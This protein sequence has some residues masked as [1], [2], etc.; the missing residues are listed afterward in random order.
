[1]SFH[2]PILP[3]LIP[4]IGGLLMLLPP[5]IGVERYRHRRVA[6]LLLTLLQVACGIWLMVTVSQHGAL[7]YA[8][9][10]WQP[11]FGIILYADLLSSMLIALTSFLGLGIT[12]YSF[13]GTDREGKYYHPLIQF[14]LLGISG[15]F[16]TNDLFNLF[17]FF[18]VL[19]IASYALMVHGGGKQKTLANVHYVIL[20]LIGSSLF[21]IAL[22]T[23]YAA[24]GT[25][26]IAD[27]SQRMAELGPSQKVIAQVGGS[28]LLVVFGLKAAMLPLHFWLPQTYEA[29]SAPVAA[30]FA[31]MT[32]V[33]VY[34]IFR[35][36]T[37]IFGDTAGDLA[38]MAEPWIWVLAILT[39]TAG[40][41]G[42]LASPNLR[43]LNSN[44]IIVSV[45][46][47]LI[48]FALRTP[49]AT[50]AGLFYL[51][52][53]TVISATL[54]LVADMVGQQRGKALDRFVLAR[55]VKQQTA[56]GILFF[57]AAL[58]VAGLPPF[59]GFL[60][61]LMV[62]QAATGAAEKLWVWTFVLISS[63]VTIVA[64]SRAGTTLFWRYPE[65]SDPSD[66]KSA[67]IWQLSGAVLLLVASP[68]MVVFGGY[69]I[70]YTTDA[71][72]QLHNVPYLLEA[73]NLREGAQ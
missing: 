27:M 21:L 26:N 14:Q 70:Q 45:G 22:G 19:L 38:G 52:H 11:P 49:E 50:A 37:V 69:V 61:K 67:S 51:I 40:S 20:N 10:D 64:L 47:L 73:M 59:S 13:A 23:L 63:L 72:A 44:L 16:L 42:A 46:T 35:V 25:L 18:E 6:T 43:T 12:L 29:A 54:F 41:I 28:L 48:A 32:K 7:M 24:T 34:C 30:L 39:V 62:L 71:A 5:F 8:V 15:A 65:N 53:S 55:K 36:F 68:A 58:A 3:I 57:I 66:S 56:F 1:M 60:G 4:L 2:L 9:G 31:I 33:G 17:V